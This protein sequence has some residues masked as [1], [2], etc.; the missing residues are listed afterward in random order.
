MPPCHN[1]YLCFMMYMEVVFLRSHLEQ[2]KVGFTGLTTTI[3]ITNKKRGRCW[4]PHLSVNSNPLVENQVFGKPQ[5]DT[6]SGAGWTVV[7]KKESGLFLRSL[8][9]SWETHLKHTH[10][11]THT[12]SLSLTLSLSPK[13]S[14]VLQ[15]KILERNLIPG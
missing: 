6:E 15:D 13:S 11:H 8:Y 12:H 9:S 4:E 14:W 7:T 5:Q 10:T 3:A 1:P 2:Q